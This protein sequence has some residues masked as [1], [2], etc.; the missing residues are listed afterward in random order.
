MPQLEDDKIET[1][2][3]AGHTFIKA[4][5]GVVRI[6]GNIEIQLNTKE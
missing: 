5:I 2:K 6:G 3:V 1:F 4:E